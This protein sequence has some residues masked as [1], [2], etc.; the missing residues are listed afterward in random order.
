MKACFEVK[1]LEICVSYTMADI[2]IWLCFLII[3]SCRWLWHIGT[4][5]IQSGVM[6][7]VEN[8]VVRCTYRFFVLF[9]IEL[10]AI[11]LYWAILVS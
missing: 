3:K 8:D 4:L 9:A 6:A 5:N 1:Y 10:L 2:K 7:F 11:I